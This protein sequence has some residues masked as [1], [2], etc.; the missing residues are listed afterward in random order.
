MFSKSHRLATRGEEENL[1]GRPSHEL[2]IRSGTSLTPTSPVP[3]PSPQ[4]T[5]PLTPVRHSYYHRGN[6]AS[7]QP[8]KSITSPVTVTGATME[9][10]S[11]LINDP[12]TGEP[13]AR[14]V[15]DH[16]SPLGS[17][18]S[19]LEGCGADMATQEKFWSHVARIRELQSEVARMHIAMESIGR[20]PEP[21]P[22]K[23]KEKEKDKDKPRKFRGQTGRVG[24]AAGTDQETGHSAS[25]TDHAGSGKDTRSGTKAPTTGPAASGLDT[26]EHFAKRKD[27][28]QDIMKKV[29]ALVF[30]Y[31]YS[32]ITRFNY[33]KL[34]ELSQQISDFH[35]L[36]TPEIT[37]P[38]SPTRQQTFLAP[39]TPPQPP[40]LSISTPTPPAAVHHAPRAKTHLS[41]TSLHGQQPPRLAIPQAPL[42]GS[43]TQPGTPSKSKPRSAISAISNDGTFH[44]SPASIQPTP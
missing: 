36:P 14:L 39:H 27:A 21:E 13:K 37:F 17:P 12:Y 19:L 18:F 23:E 9:S 1:L 44:E 40:T 25:D 32:R 28:I 43:Q 20:Q 38:I 5:G 34:S 16:P 35:Q 41:P 8:E 26:G 31:L 4:P 30:V 3:P 11:T 42:L 6:P 33:L 24:T 22:A 10:Q 15:P 2:T 7:I 29:V